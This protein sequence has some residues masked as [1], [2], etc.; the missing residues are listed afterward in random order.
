MVDHAVAN[1]CLK[2]CPVCLL[3]ID[4]AMYNAYFSGITPCTCWPRCVTLTQ[5]VELPVR[6]YISTHPGNVPLHS[7][8]FWWAHQGVFLYIVHVAC[9]NMILPCLSTKERSH[10]YILLETGS[11]NTL[12]HTSWPGHIYF[13]ASILLT[14]FTWKLFSLVV[15]CQPIPEQCLSAGISPC[16]VPSLKFTPYPNV[17]THAWSIKYRLKK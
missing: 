5:L 8:T 9:I 13:R 14:T 12:K 7:A 2:L 15:I 1:R 6:S 16:L 3:N 4:Q 10:S 11:S 17:W